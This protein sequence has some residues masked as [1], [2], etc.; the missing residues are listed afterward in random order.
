MQVHTDN[1][2]GLRSNDTLVNKK[3]EFFE[4]LYREL[5]GI[6]RFR[7]I[8]IL[9]D[10]NRRTGPKLEDNIVDKFGDTTTNDN[11]LG[12]GSTMQAE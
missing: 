10:V 2:W 4:Q 7:E 5:F 8:I 9:G 11:G 1:I 3:D 6:S 12:I